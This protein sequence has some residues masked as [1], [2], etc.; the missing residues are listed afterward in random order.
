[1]PAV[2]KISQGKEKCQV[3]GS[4]P[5]SDPRVELTPASDRITVT[6]EPGAE[7]RLARVEG[8]DTSGRM[9]P[10]PTGMTSIPLDP[11]FGSRWKVMP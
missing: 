10:G 3:S 11:A 1:M 9:I 8:L 2:V 6:L 4:D 7:D 5:I